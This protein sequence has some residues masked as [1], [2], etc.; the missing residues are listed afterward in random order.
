M[1]KLAIVVAPLVLYAAIL[2]VR[3]ALGRMPRRHALNVETSVL[4]LLYFFT[5]AA[6]G[7]FWVANQQLPPFDWHYLLGYLTATLVVVHLGFN[8]RVVLRHARGP[9]R[10]QALH[11]R[12][13][14]PRSVLR[15]AAYVLGLGVVFFLGMRAGKTEIV[16]EDVQRAA[17]TEPIARYHAFSSHSRGGVVSRA[18]SIS[19]GEE[20]P[21]HIDRSAL[22]A[23]ELPP[24]DLGRQPS[25]SVSIADLSLLLWATAGVTEE[26]GP[27]ELRAAASSGALFPTEV[28]VLA[29]SVEGLEPGVYAYDPRDHHLALVA[30]EVPSL[31][32]LGAPEIGD[33]SVTLVFTCVFRRSG[34][35]YRDRAY[36][37]AVADAGHA[38][39]NTIAASSAIGLGLHLLPRFDDGRMAA[40]V[41]ADDA[42]EG[43]VAAAALGR[44]MADGIAPSALVTPQIDDP[45]ALPLGATSLA[46]R[47]TS[48][49]L[50]P[51][52]ATSADGLPLPAPQPPGRPIL[53]LIRTRRSV[54]EYDA[55]A[56]T[57]DELG[58]VMG[59]ALAPEPRLSRSLRVTLIANRVTGLAPGAYRYERA[60]RD[61]RLLR[62]DELAADAGRAA[63]D[64][65]VIG[66]APAV[67]VIS[68]DRSVIEAEGPRSYRQAFLEAGLVGARLYLAA[69]EASLGGCS[70]GAFYDEEAA[71]LI[72][73]PLEEEWPVHF[74]ALGAPR[75]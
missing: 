54:R 42:E 70:V 39:G 25:G 34:Q 17:G 68:A 53:E 28:Y 37:Y 24:P 12:V 7:I 47:A 49:A 11:E 9:R 32:A 59:G 50:V 48:L 55:R 20:V 66:G 51:E 8:L 3:K 60:T 5:T 27:V 13:A 69:G 63:L 38:I 15:P 10:G 35:K 75:T 1:Q 62:A 16:I 29:R 19:W 43:V 30:P 4:L 22:P 6:L 52:G 41:G 36:R 23:V 31:A 26:R 64:Q 57:V 74:F 44:G 67:F 18:P 2:G 65:E 46:H 14:K 71:R 40:A 61:L 73:V 45:G 72:G 58:R 33:P 21:R 56:L